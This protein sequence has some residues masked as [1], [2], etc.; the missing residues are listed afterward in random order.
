MIEAGAELDHFD[1]LSDDWLKA[2][3]FK[4]H[5]FDRQPDKHWLLWIGGCMG[6]HASYE[7]I[8]IEV[9]LNRDGQWFCWL[10]SD[11]AGRYH[12]FIHIRMIESAKD[13]V[14][15]IRGLTGME[16]DPRNALYG[17]LYTNEQAAKIR[18]QDERLDARLKRDHPS[19]YLPEK[20]ESLGG[21][22]IDHVDAYE[23]ARKENSHEQG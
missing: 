6:K 5:Q 19:W 9:A 3:G 16:F 7:D 21:P 14:G 18:E 1:L 22:L 20:D 13:L 15:I 4:W 2:N 12:R 17:H 10:R 8:G 23:K 11:S